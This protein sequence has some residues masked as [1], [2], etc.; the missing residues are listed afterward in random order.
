MS[1]YYYWPRLF[2]EIQCLLNCHYDVGHQGLELY[3]RIKFHLPQCFPLSL[4]RAHTYAIQN[5]LAEMLILFVFR[6]IHSLHNFNHD[7]VYRVTEL[8][9]S[10]KFPI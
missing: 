6:E 8:E 9:L 7:D 1:H 4:T 3:P 2:Q 10:T 5:V